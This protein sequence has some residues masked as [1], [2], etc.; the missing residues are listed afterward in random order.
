MSETATGAGRMTVA[1]L[2]EAGPRDISIDIDTTPADLLASIEPRGSEL[3]LTTSAGVALEDHLPLGDQVA[4]GAFLAFAAA[5]SLTTGS[6]ALADR[7]SWPAIEPRY[8]F[9]ASGRRTVV[10]L[11]AA[12]AALVMVAAQLVHLLASVQVGWVRWL[13]AVALGAAALAVAVRRRP[14]LVTVLIGPILG[15]GAGV[16]LAPWHVAAT[17]AQSVF[18]ALTVGSLCAALVAVVRYSASRRQDARAGRSAG[19]AEASGLTG[20]AGLVAVLIAG[21]AVVTALCRLAGTDAATPAILLAGMVPLALRALP[22]VALRIPDEELLDLP[23]IMKAVRS[24]RATMPDSPRRIRR[25]WVRG[26]VE[27][28]AASR[29]AGV[30]VLCGLAPVLLPAVIVRAQPAGVE[31]WAAIGVVACVALVLALSPRSWAGGATKVIPRVALVVV[32]LEIALLWPAGGRESTLAVG[33]LLLAGLL[34]VTMSPV[35]SGFRSVRWSRTGDIVEAMAVGLVLPAALLAAGALSALP[36][37]T[38]G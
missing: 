38:A 31:G 2:G 36:V 20:A 17:P 13:S 26:H 21:A 34:L 11:V 33:L 29:L 5:G 15:L 16:A 19:A 10:G 8:R 22:T 23:V 24:V 9:A 14:Q 35:A 37:L 30:L 1:L 3:V 27:A 4:P 28:A 25:P 7:A 12:A 6:R 32:L 18:L